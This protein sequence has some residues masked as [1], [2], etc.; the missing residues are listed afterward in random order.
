MLRAQQLTLA[1]HFFLF[2]KVRLPLSLLFAVASVSGYA[3]DTDT[4]SMNSATLAP[5]SPT[6]VYKDPLLRKQWQWFPSKTGVNIAPVWKSGITGGGST[7]AWQAFK[8]VSN[9]PE[10]TVVIGVIDTWVEPNHEDLKV[11]LYW[12]DKVSEGDSPYYSESGL[13][14]DFI[15]TEALPKDDAETE[16]VNEAEGQIYTAESH[17]TFVSGMAAAVGGNDL[18]VVGAAPGATIAGL[19]IG[20]DDGLSIALAEEAAWW[21]SGVGKSGNSLVYSGEA[22]IQVKNC[23]FGSFWNANGDIYKSFANSIA[24]TS[25]NNVI[26]VFAAGNQRGSTDTHPG[27]TGWSSNGNN[28]FIINVAA[29]N[30]SGTYTDFSSF[31]SNVFISA[32]GEAVVSTDRTGEL[33]Y[34]AGSVAGTG[35]DDGTT[36][37]TTAAVISDANYADGDGTS[38]S[39]PLVAGV[40][41]LGKEI[42]PV[43]DVRWAK[44]ALAYSSGYGEK[45]N[46][47]T[48]KDENGNWVQ[49]SGYTITEEDN[50]VL[51]SAEIKPDTGGIPAVSD[52]TTPSN[53]EISTGNWQK[54]QGGYWFNN[55]YGFGLVNPDGF[56]ETVKDIAYTTVETQAVGSIEKGTAQETF[57]LERSV[58]YSVGTTRTDSNAALVSVLNQRVETVS[59]TVNFSEAALASAN[60]NIGSLRVTLTDPHG[61]SSVLVQDCSGDPERFTI[62][63]EMAGV[64]SSYTFL[65]NAFWG[66]SYSGNL[67]DWKISVE[68]DI[69]D[70]AV[71]VNSAGWVTVSAVDFS[72]GEFVSESSSGGVGVGGVVNAHALVLDE[73]SFAV[74]GELYVEDAVYVNGG[75]FTIQTGGQVG[76]Y[77]N[78]DLQ[79]G[80]IYVQTGGSASVAGTGTFSRG[81]HVYGGSLGLSG[82]GS[83]VGEITVNGGA[84]SVAKSGED[85]PSFGNI[86]L[87]NGAVD[88]GAGMKFTSMITLYGGGLS[89]GNNVGGG[90]LR[91]YGGNASALGDAKFSTI[92]VGT[93]EPGAGED[94]ADL[95]YGGDIVVGGQL[96][97]TN[98]VSFSGVGTGTVN[99]GA[100]FVGNVEVGGQANLQ[101]ANRSG[102]D[103]ALNVSESGLVG[104]S[105]E[106]GVSGDISIVSGTLAA[107]GVSELRMT[108]TATE[109]YDLN[110]NKAP[111]LAV[112]GKGTFAVG[113]TTI[114]GADIT[115]NA[116]ATLSFASRTREDYDLLT[117]SSDKSVN[118]GHLSS[119]TLADPTQTGNSVNISYHF[120]DAIP[121]TAALIKLDEGVTF[122]AQGVD[123]D[124]LV[125][126]A[127][128]LYVESSAGEFTLRD[129]SF[130]VGANAAG[131]MLSLIPEKGAVVENHRL[132]YTSQTEQQS[133]IQMSLLKNEATA[134]SFLDAV[135]QL[136]RVSDLLRAYDDLGA[137]ANIMAIDELHDKQ[138]NAITG[139]ISRRSRELRSGFIHAD[140]F[141]NPLTAYSGFTFSARPNQVAAK[142]FIP[143]ASVEDDYPLMVWMNGGYSFSEADDAAMAV[144]STES[145]MLNLAFGV[146]YEISSD[147]ALG[148]FAGYTNGRTKF[149]GGDRTEIQSRNVG[150]Y[151]AG[152]HTDDIG[153]LYYT[154]VVA[155]GYEEYDFSR[156][157]AVGGLNSSAKASP[158]GW[159]GIVFIEGGYEWKMDKFSTGPVASLRYVANN[160]DGYTESSSAAWMCQEVDDVNYDSLQSS[161]GWR[162]AYRAD[163][164]TATILPELR[165]SWNHEFLGTDES[166]DARLAMPNSGTY[167][168]KIT[169]TGDNYM[170]AGAGVSVML[171]DVSTVSFDYDMQFLRDDAD[172]THS[173]NVMFRTRF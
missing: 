61:V 86:T 147:L 135:D 53:T 59:V 87:Y 42:C 34:N 93:V 88:V 119:L 56:V 84:F 173:F 106:M 99:T 7:G 81:V 41:A 8:K 6:S 69:L 155:F 18:G 66:S 63:A 64:L 98:G 152:A 39:S 107:S 62:G 121:Y 5:T 109:N 46:I 127:P 78:A 49:K 43:M 33:G 60:F 24:S 82:K 75:T 129:L 170:T 122:N 73:K 144:S 101:F 57:G 168:C 158:D 80:A 163:F 13:S 4:P 160:I 139:A 19:H 94:G 149:D 100:K 125:S 21:Q 132:Y 171:G 148:I 16:D 131:D 68:Y 29:T 51:S 140:V 40:V 104:W 12:K 23:S 36:G 83:L 150:V 108:G 30:N 166:F 9:L 105:G 2:M 85:T 113:K 128:Q 38:F 142:G 102:V 76:V 143:Y 112:G 110:G 89:V 169:N 28:R 71:D 156:K 35:D 167:S 120:G 115:L 130:D 126:D 47:D 90:A 172:P 17:G 77:E 164:E 20:N 44:H 15:N 91:V 10:T 133:A 55:N 74:G 165:V 11:A 116:G 145:N 146:D 45:P 153:S 26:Y 103:G 31:G 50:G 48:E 65:T 134:K 70:N 22:A 162:L 37:T 92:S 123:F 27:S 25:K 58:E 161:I 111:T 136:D 114:Y 138:A 124:V 151:L 159:Q 157:L 67:E 141:S 1:T 54:N 96:T 137:P 52:E 95:Y 3:A 14:R 32:P 154:A 118:N 72:M 97:V 79:K 117:L